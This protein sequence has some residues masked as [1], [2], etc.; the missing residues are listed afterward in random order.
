[1]PLAT[2]ADLQAY[3][4]TNDFQDNFLFRQIPQ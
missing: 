1:V 4:T 2:V 3:F